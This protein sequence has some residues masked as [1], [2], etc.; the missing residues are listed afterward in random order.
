MHIENGQKFSRQNLS[1]PAT[2]KFMEETCARYGV[3]K[4]IVSDNGKQFTSHLFDHFC[5]QNGIQQSTTPPYHPQSNGQAERFVDTFK[6]GIKKIQQGGDLQSAVNTFLFTYRYT[7]NKYIGNKSPAELMLGRKLRTVLDLVRP[8][9]NTA[10][11][12]NEKQNSQCNK[13]H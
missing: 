11:R 3:P 12:I 1:A 10:A 9:K 6:R 8:S 2:V 4:T 7:P 5:K 13:H